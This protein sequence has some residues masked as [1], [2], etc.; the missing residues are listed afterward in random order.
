MTLPR[1]AP[2]GAEGL[3]LDMAVVGFVG[4]IQ[5]SFGDAHPVGG[6]CEPG[7]PNLEIEI[8]AGR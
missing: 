1:K 2:P 8:G 7:G 4:I 3:G 6:A 5:L